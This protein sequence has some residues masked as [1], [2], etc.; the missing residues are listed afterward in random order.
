MSYGNMEVEL[1]VGYCSTKFRFAEKPWKIKKHPF[2]HANIFCLRDEKI[3][4][5]LLT[6]KT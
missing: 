2:C 5:Y 1:P 4:S 6:F 3:Q